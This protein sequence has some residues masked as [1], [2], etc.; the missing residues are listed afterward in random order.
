MSSEIL[1][2]VEQVREWI[3]SNPETVECRELMSL[4]EEQLK[5]LYPFASDPE[6]VAHS[7]LHQQMNQCSQKYRETRTR[8]D[9]LVRTHFPVFT[10]E[11]RYQRI[12]EGL[13]DDT[14]NY[15]TLK[16]VLRQVERYRR[17]E[18]TYE[19]GFNSGLDFITRKSNLP[20]DFFNRMKE[21]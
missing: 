1:K 19:E 18:I 8:L 10:S 4:N 9:Q 2:Q 15:E 11:T 7:E 3:K 13:L 12:Y 14:L 17:G 21:K 6:Y 5:K 20:K 16:D